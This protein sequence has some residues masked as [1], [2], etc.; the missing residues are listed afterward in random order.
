MITGIMKF[1]VLKYLLL[2]I[3]FGFILLLTGCSSM[4][5]ISPSTTPITENDT[6]TKLGRTAGSSGGV[7]II[8]MFPIFSNDPAGAARDKAIKSSGGNALIEVAME[9]N[10]IPLGIVNIYW[11]TVEGTAVHVEHGGR[12]VE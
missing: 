3:G 1:R 11:T 9:E 5:T 12:I 6:Y 7:L 4:I 8:G 10:A 2:S